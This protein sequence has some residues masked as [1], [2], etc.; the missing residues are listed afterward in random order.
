MPRV[1]VAS[2]TMQ[3]SRKFPWPRMLGPVSRIVRRLSVPAELAGRRLDQAAAALLPEFS[4]SRLRAWIDAGE[5]TVGGHGAKPRLLLK[6]GEELALE[7]E[8]E[9]AVDD[10][11]RAD[12]A[13]R[14]SCR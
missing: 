10:G 2:S 13:R 6:G 12:P 14:R 11:T 5:L 1:F 8:L 4:R 9:A 3:Y 7:T